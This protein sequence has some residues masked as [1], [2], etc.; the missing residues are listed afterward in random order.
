MCNLLQTSFDN[1]DKLLMER[2][3]KWFRKVV[4]EKQGLQIEKWQLFV[5]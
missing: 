3:Y 4:W 5:S 1:M 2:D